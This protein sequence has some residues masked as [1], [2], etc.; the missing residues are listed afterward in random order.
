[1]GKIL[2]SP[3]VLISRKASHSTKNSAGNQMKRKF[4]VRN[5]KNLG[6]QPTGVSSIPEITENAVAF[7]L[8]IS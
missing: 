5:I 3:K 8:E 7:L 1:M 2:Q 4:P 6:S